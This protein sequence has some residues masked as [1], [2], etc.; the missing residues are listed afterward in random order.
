MCR[1]TEICMDAVRRK[2]QLLALVLL[3]AVI[4]FPRLSLLPVR[5][6][7]TR[8]AEGADHMIAS[9]DWVVPRQQ[10]R[11]YVDRPPLGSWSMAAVGLVRGTIDVVAIRLPSVL[12]ILLTSII[13]Y[14]Y[15][16]TFLTPTGALAAGAAYASLLQVLEIGRLG[17]NEAS[18]ALLLSGAMLAW[19]AIYLR[20]A[21]RAL[22][23]VNWL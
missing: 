13:T 11:V 17:E 1:F 23:V 5:G 15:A 2:W 7:E 8:W 22:S 21:S 10:E 20:G 14:L 12:A 4:Y 19:H 16:R 3:V 6:E 18:Y 9:G